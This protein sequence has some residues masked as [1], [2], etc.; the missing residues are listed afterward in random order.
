[1]DAEALTLL[2]RGDRRGALSLRMRAYARPLHRH[3]CI[4]L[5][6]EAFAADVVQT[7]F[8]EAFRDLEGFRERSSLRSWL[9]GIA[10]HR[11]LD[12]LRGHRRVEAREAL[13]P[14]PPD[15]A[16]SRPPADSSPE[17]RDVVSALERCLSERSPGTRVAVLLRLQ[18][19]MPYAEMA[20][21]CR[22]PTGTLQARVCRALPVLRQCLAR[23]GLEP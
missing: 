13:D 9:F 20:R 5:R 2:G 16:D 11:C 4:V 10:R 1:M 6:D 3:C 7:V 22:E 15:R 23:Q 18:E 8:V 21:V 12:A 19:G 14:E 17:R